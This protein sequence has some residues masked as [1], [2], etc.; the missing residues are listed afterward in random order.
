MYYD[1]DQIKN[2]LLIKVISLTIKLLKYNFKFEH[3]TEYNKKRVLLH[4][5][6]YIYFDITMIYLSKI[7]C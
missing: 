3:L 1:D 4:I 7:I 5:S 6:S 2:I